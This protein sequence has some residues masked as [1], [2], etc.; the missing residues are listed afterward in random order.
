VNVH[1]PGFLIIEYG[2][3][4]KHNVSLLTSDSHPTPADLFITI[5][6]SHSN[7]CSR[8]L[9]VVIVD[10]HIKAAARDSPLPPDYDDSQDMMHFAHCALLSGIRIP[11]S[12]T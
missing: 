9:V 5:A 4:P 6:I 10:V 3:A 12:C 1:G 8:L 11:L 7:I 2:P